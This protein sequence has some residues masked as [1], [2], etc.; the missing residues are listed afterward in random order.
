MH[1]IAK[2]P[3]NSPNT[4]Y[5]TLPLFGKQLQC[6]WEQATGIRPGFTPS[7]AAI[8][9]SSLPALA[10]IPLWPAECSVRTVLHVPY[11]SKLMLNRSSSSEIW[12]CTRYSY[13]IFVSPRS[14]LTC[15]T[16]C[17]P[18]FVLRTVLLYF[19]FFILIEATVAAV[20]AWPMNSATIFVH[21]N[22]VLSEKQMYLF[23][24]SVVMK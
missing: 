6:W 14:C 3:A 4:C 11:S 13:R 19:F 15:G 21:Q 10:C 23:F 24:F 16:L 17:S 22:I 18:N 12:T 5:G 2:T 9:R 7:A 20:F 8:A 1:I